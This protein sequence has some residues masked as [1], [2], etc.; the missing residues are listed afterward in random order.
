MWAA[1]MNEDG[2][3]MRN[4]KPVSVLLVAIASAAVHGLGAVLFVPALSFLFLVFG[5]PAQFGGIVASTDR[6][7]TLAVIAPIC[8]AAVG[9]VGGA[10][11]ASLFNMFV[12]DRPRP[13]FVV[14]ETLRVPSSASLSDVA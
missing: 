2:N 4:A 8:C 3:M 10:V 9:F 12:K 1:S 5:S 11:I 14:R 13:E 6:G 7:M